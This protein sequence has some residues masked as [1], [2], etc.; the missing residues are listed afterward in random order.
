MNGKDAWGMP[1]LHCVVSHGD[2]EPARREDPSAAGAE[3]LEA[4]GA[5]DIR[6]QANVEMPGMAIHELG[7]ARMGTD[8]KKSVLNPFNQTHDVK[9]LFVM[10]GASFV[11]SACQNPTLTMMAITVRACD[12]LIDRFHRNDV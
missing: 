6:L 9:N 4:A 1:A 12:H 11:S 10:D 2:N 5:K 3:R 8:P 7:T